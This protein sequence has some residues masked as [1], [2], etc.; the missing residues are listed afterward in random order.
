[1]SMLFF[2]FNSY[3]FHGHEKTHDK[4]KFRIHVDVYGKE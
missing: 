3:T 1:M 2:N 4:K